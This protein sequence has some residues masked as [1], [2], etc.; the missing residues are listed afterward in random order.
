MTAENFSKYNRKDLF[1]H[2]VIYAIYGLNFRYLFNDDSI[3]YIARVTLKRSVIAVIINRINFI[4]NFGLFLKIEKN[5]NYFWCMLN[6]A[7]TESAGQEQQ[8]LIIN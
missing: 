4:N 5:V 2:S 3:Q 8:T 7:L 1:S 6:L